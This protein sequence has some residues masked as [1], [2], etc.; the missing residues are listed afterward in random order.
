MLAQYR[1]PRPPALTSVLGAGKLAE[2]DQDWWLGFRR[3][4]QRPEFR[5]SG[6]SATESHGAQERLHRA[7]I[8]RGKSLE[9]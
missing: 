2:T 5:V 8:S 9:E 7:G 6:P 4:R 1:A 3:H